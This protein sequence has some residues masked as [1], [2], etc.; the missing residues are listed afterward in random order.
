MHFQGRERTLPPLRW[1]L[2]P[3]AVLLLCAG[4]C[5]NRSS[6]VQA[7]S[8]E[9]AAFVRLIMPA[10]IEIQHYLTRPFD[11][12]G[13]GNA[14]GLEVILATCDSFGDPVKCIGTFQFELHRRRRASGDKFGARIA[15]WRVTID[16]GQ[17]LMEYWHRYSRYYRFPLKLSDGTLPPGRY[18]LSARLATPT[19]EKL[20]DDYE[21][22][23]DGP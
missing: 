16:T 10:R 12:A 21:F 18:I 8:P 4:G 3:T 17:S 11:Y 15:L 20:Y 7:E 14:D 22:T 13:T 5:Q 6:D 1:A 9:L 19:G 2:L 23:H